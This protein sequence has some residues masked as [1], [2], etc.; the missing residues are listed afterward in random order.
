MELPEE[1]VEKLDRQ[2][3][4]GK[5]VEVWSAFLMYRHYAQKPDTVKSSFWWK[6]MPP[7]VRN[8][9]QFVAARRL[10]WNQDGKLEI[11]EILLK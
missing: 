9:A 10:V 3:E 4:S 5:D 6:N 1:T 2:A 8:F 11:R 7:V